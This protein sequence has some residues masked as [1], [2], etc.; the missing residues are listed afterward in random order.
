MASRWFVIAVLLYVSVDVVNPSVPGMFSF[1]QEHLFIDG[2]V[3]V[4]CDG[5]QPRPVTVTPVAR[6]GPA[7][8]QR[9]SPAVVGPLRALA[10]LGL[11]RPALRSHARHDAVPD[12]ARTPSP[13]DDS[14]HRQSRP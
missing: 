7:D 1:E 11:V 4:K 14:L 9:T 13:D 8:V 3:R 2:A 5:A 12:S 10:W 6:P